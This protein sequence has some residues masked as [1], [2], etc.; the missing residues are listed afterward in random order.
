MMTTHS[1]TRPP[2]LSEARLIRTT[3]FARLPAMNTF[4]TQNTT[5]A[6][7]LEHNGL[8]FEWL[9]QW[10]QIPD[11]PAGRNNGRTHAVSVLDDGRIVVFHQAVPGVLFFDA[12]GNLLESWGDRF[13]GAH[14]MSLTR[15]DGKQ[16]LWLVDQSSCE[17]CRVD[18]QGNLQQR[19]EAPPVD[20]RPNGRYTPT[21]ALDNPENGDI[22]VA[23]GYGG[24]A[25]Y[26][27]AADGSYLGKLTGEEGAGR[28]AC[29]HAIG[30]G[31]DNNLYI[32]DRGNHRIAVYDAQGKYLKHRDDVTHSPCCFDFNN[33]LILV[34][35]LRSGIKLLDADLNVVANLGENP[36]LL[37]DETR[38]EGWP[39]LKGTEHVKPGLFNSPHGGCFAPNGD[40]YI[41]EWIVGGRITKL[42]KQ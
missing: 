35:E 36:I 20:Q 29:P 15:R 4:N 11:T 9:D 2:Q 10:A 7:T 27:Y 37:K 25:V 33:G 38:T 28:F 13:T 8:A 30:M 5:T 40:I 41:V 34:P 1:K 6:L 32:A 3:P 12:D 17:V 24:S 39:N 26:R 31:P 19:L 14:G 42:V 21:W 16:Q 22:W 18:L 23:D